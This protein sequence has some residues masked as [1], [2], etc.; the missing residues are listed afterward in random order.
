M[1]NMTM[2]AKEGD[3]TRQWFV[4]DAE[5]QILGRLATEVA[6]LLRGKHK[7]IYTPSLDC[8]DF[9]VVVNASKIAVTGK[10]LRDKEYI[11]HTGWPGGFRKT[12]LEKLLAEH[13]ERVIEL[14][15]RR[16]L[17]KSRLGRAQFGK[18]KV[19]AGAE[20]PHQAQQ[21][22]PFKLG[23]SGRQLGVPAAG[24]TR[25]SEHIGKEPQNG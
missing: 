18:L 8:G 9:V 25:S 12:N 10:K 1:N 19:Y 16:M 21:P 13:P 14:A 11:H 23:T 7:P 15:I 6:T 22:R 17:P 2:S 20:H 24:A 5:G 3:V 4:V